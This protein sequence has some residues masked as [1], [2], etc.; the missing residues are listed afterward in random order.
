[1]A[2]LETI[3]DLGT[4]PRVPGGAALREA[5]VRT[6]LGGVTFAATVVALDL[7]TVREAAVSL[8]RFGALEEPAAPAPPPPFEDRW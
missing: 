2:S 3:G 5:A 1:M 8:R 6:V 7:E 4:G